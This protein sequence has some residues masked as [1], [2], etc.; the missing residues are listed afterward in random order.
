MIK[1]KKM[2]FCEQNLERGTQEVLDYANSNLA[3]KFLIS[4]TRCLGECGEC[5]SN[6]IVDLHGKLL[7]NETPKGLLKMIEN[8]LKNN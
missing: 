2:T 3:D 6:C 4:T 7:V 5:F 8:E 1:M